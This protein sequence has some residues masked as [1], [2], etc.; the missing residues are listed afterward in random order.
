[1]IYIMQ[2]KQY[3]LQQSTTLELK[4][5][6]VLQKKYLYAYS[7]KCFNYRHQFA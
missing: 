4:Q 3:I 5:L 7:A 6:R 1:M 2:F